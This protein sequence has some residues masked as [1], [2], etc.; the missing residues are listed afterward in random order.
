M[1]VGAGACP[2]GVGEP[3]P[4]PIVLDGD[5]TPETGYLTRS[6][7][8][9]T[10]DGWLAT[11][12]DVGSRRPLAVGDRLVALDRDSPDEF[13][14]EVVAVDLAGAGGEVTYTLRWL[15][16]SDPSAAPGLDSTRQWLTR[17]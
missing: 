2:E 4:E 9:T 15:S 10:D 8:L 7:A 6:P 12:L 16:D 11:S 3:I 5:G 13:L 1:T 17:P 14:V